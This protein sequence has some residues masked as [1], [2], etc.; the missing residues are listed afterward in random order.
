MIN[1]AISYSN[2][3]SS[4]SAIEFLKNINEMNL[5]IKIPILLL[6]LLPF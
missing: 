3:G 6:V 5:F 2:E 4:S 1:M